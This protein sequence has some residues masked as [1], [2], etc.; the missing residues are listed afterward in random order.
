MLAVLL[1]PRAWW[2]WSVLALAALLRVAVALQVGLGLVHDRGVLKHLWLLSLRDVAAFWVWF[3]SFGDNKVH[4]RGEIFILEK[5]RI[6]PAEP[7]G[8]KLITAADP[9]DKV[10]A[11]W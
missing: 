3:A 7:H 8:G 10:S 9:D 5:G 11:H 1:A 6:R 4:W 2:S